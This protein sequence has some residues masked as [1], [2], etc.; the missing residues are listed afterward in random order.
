MPASRSD[1]LVDTDWLAAHLN[2]A[3][4]RVVDATSFLP[5]VPR[6]GRAE[7]GQKHIPG[8]VFFS[9]D[10][11]ADRSTDLPHMLPSPDFFA[12][13]V[14]KLGIGNDTRVIVY[15]ANGGTSASARVWWTFRIFGHDNVAILNGGLPKWLAEGRPVEAGAVKPAQR[16]FKAA[17][18]PN[19]V[20]SRQ[21]VIANIASKAEQVVDART[22]GRFNGK[23]PEP[24]PSKKIG[25]IP[26]S[27][28][29]P[30][31]TLVDPERNMVL[32]SPEEIAKR[33]KD[34]GVDLTKPI[35]T[36]CGSGVTASFLALGLYLIGR[37]D[38]A[39]YD[40]SWAE[41]GNAPD[42]PVEP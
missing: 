24:R 12:E 17:F 29:V 34:A 28:C 33:F 25:R 42:T 19:M 37:E 39:V 5:N 23:E 3:N 13:E 1:A 9:V 14:G 15:D 26:G 4:V 22:L 16:T 35:V 20:R 31:G 11:I 21:Q 38:I 2:D 7:H 8:A 10:E 6:D 18:R 30:V 27:Y 36:T 40:G 32:R 41:W